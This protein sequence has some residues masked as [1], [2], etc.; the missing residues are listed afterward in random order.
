MNH[1]IVY[2]IACVL[3]FLPSAFSIIGYDC[4]HQ[5]KN[6]THLSLA[7]IAE[8]NMKLDEVVEEVV[9]IQLLQVSNI[10]K[11]HVQQCKVEVTR[12]IVVCGG[13]ISYTKSV[14][15]GV[16]NYVEKISKTDCEA[17]NKYK[18][19][20]VAPGRRVSSLRLNGTTTSTIV[21]VGRLQ[22][23]GKCVGGL[24]TVGPNTYEDVVVQ[25]SLKI[26]LEDY[27]TD[28]VLDEDAILLRSLRKYPFKDGECM[29]PD[30]GST[31][32]DYVDTPD[33]LTT[34]YDVL[35]EGPANKTY[36]LREG[37]ASMNIYTVAWGDSLF[38]LGVL[39]DISVCRFNGFQTEHPKLVIVPKTMKEYLFKKRPIT[40][41]NS[42]LFT[43]MNSKFVYLEKHLSRQMKD[44]YADLMRHKCEL[45]RE[46]LETQ[47]VIG[48][49]HPMQFAR[50]IQKKPGF[51]AIIA[52]EAIHLIECQPVEVSFRQAEECYSEL[53]VLYNNQSYFLTPHNHIL[54]TI[55]S[56]QKCST[57]LSSLWIMGGKWW[58][59]SPYMTQV[60]P[61]QVITPSSSPTWE[62][63][64][65]GD[66]AV[67][68]IL[69]Y[70]KLKELNS[71]ITLQGNRY[72]IEH[73]I[74]AGSQDP[75][76]NARQGISMDGFISDARITAGVTSFYEKS[77][78]L[79]WSFS[80]YSAGVFGAVMILK[81]IK[82][83]IDSLIQ[84]HILFEVF[85]W[86]WRLLFSC[87]DVMTACFLYRAKQK[88]KYFGPTKWTP[89][90]PAAPVEEQELQDVRAT[91]SG[92]RLLP[93][94][95][96]ALPKNKDSN[97]IV[98][99]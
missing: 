93:D 31:Y 41:G 15:G 87:W 50:L 62:Y 52:G 72:G 86:S 47:L 78:S 67:Q 26:T 63:E 49:M 28:V 77:K 35:Y 84:G 70:S 68:G 25:L 51:I 88:G 60:K 66:L 17:M 91:T 57:M 61:P 75:L 12:T 13:W 46:L 8:C 43:Y 92:S 11:V 81:G 37:K 4:N 55:G 40:S 3:V 58:S 14:A 22:T 74:V 54:V 32:W 73:S 53:P 16:S 96:P 18:E 64:N 44:M 33:C 21:S 82:I 48:M 2:V 45:E 27:Y 71:M 85:G 34:Q 19:Y 95:Y 10:M 42:D 97:I 83:L 90:D 39:R 69:P 65:P 89:S 7:N 9:D 29:D 80:T 56:Q 30:G 94:I 24:F 1:H 38:S 23:D 59:V 79:F 5:N 20:T 99:T 98:K 76:L 36:V 6:V